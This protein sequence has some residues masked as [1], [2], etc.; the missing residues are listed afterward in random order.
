MSHDN[1]TNKQIEL[2]TLYSKNQTLGRL[3]HYFSE[4]LKSSGL[5][6]DKF[7]SMNQ[8]DPSLGYSLLV[9]MAL[10][11][12]C[13]LP[14]MVGILRAKAGTGQVAADFIDRAITLGLVQWQDAY[15]DLVVI[16]ALQIP[17]HVQRELDLF[18]YPLPMV[19]QPK[20]VKSNRDTGY[21]TQR[22]SII[23]KDNHHGGDVCLDH[24]NRMNSIPLKIN[25]DT[26]S[27][28]RNSWRGMDKPKPGE[29][30][31]DFE[32]RKRAFDKYDRTCFEV[33]ARIM[34]HGNVLH[35]THKYDKRGRTYCQGYHCT[36]QGNSWNKAVIQLAE[37]ELVE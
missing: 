12:R 21:M 2:E 24:I 18:Q 30:K 6:L 28:I 20:A 3:K 26:A 22:G 33:F 1:L 25:L 23:L 31:E 4:E 32:A 29:S 15:E 9:Q 7:F 11:R 35:L 16:E 37:P 10:H 5:D 8:L 14:V 19:I 27:M 13:K 36:Y 17:G 34:E